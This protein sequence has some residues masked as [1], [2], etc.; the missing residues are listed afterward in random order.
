MKGLKFKCIY[1]SGGGQEY[2]GGDWLVIT[3][4]AKSLILKRIRKEFFEGFDK[5]ILRLKKDNSCKHCLKLWGDNTFTVYPYRSGTPYY[6][7]PLVAKV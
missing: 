1:V 2:D 4:T 6:F 5:D 7:E 3:D